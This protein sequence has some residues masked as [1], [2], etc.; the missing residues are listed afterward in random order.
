[1]AIVVIILLLTTPLGRANGT[2]FASADWPAW[3]SS[4]P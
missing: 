2:L 1:V 3:P 4:A